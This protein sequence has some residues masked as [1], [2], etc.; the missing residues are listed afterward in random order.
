LQ[1][2]RQLRELIGADRLIVGLGGITNPSHAAE[3]IEAGSNVVEIYSG[4]VYRG[5]GFIADCAAA[6]RDQSDRSAPALV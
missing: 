6:L 5:P 1:V 2:V 3:F 4:L